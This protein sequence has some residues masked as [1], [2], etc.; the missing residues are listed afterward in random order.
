MPAAGGSS[1]GGAPTNDR[2]LSLSPAALSSLLSTPDVSAAASPLQRRIRHTRLFP[3]PPP[4]SSSS[5]AQGSATSATSPRI[6]T[7]VEAMTPRTV[8]KPN[9]RQPTTLW[10]PTRLTSSDC[11]LSAAGVQED[12]YTSALSW[13]THQMALALEQ[14]LVLFHPSHPRQSSS[15]VQISQEPAGMNLYEAPQ[16]FHH[17]RRATAVAMSRCSEI[18]CF[19]GL[20]NG[21]VELYEGR[22][23]GRLHCTVAFAMPEPPTDYL[24]GLLGVYDGLGSCSS[25]AAT[26]RAARALS[27][28]GSSV[29]SVSCIGTSDRYPWLGAA[30]TAARGLVALDA[31]RAQP[32]LRFGGEAERG[33]EVPPA[34]SSMQGPGAD[35]SNLYSF[36]TSSTNSAGDG[37]GLS[38]LQ[39]TA[40]Y[41]RQHDR[42]CSV[43]WNSTGS[44][45]ATGS[46]GGVVKV[47]SLS[48]PQRPLHSFL[49]DQEC[50]VKALSFHPERPYELLVGGSAGP[51]GLRTY[52]LSRAAPVLVCRGATAAPVTQALFDPAGSYAVTCAGT[53]IDIATAMGAGAAAAATAAPAASHA[54]PTSPLTTSPLQRASPSGAASRAEASMSSVLDGSPRWRHSSPARSGTGASFGATPPY[55]SCTTR[56][57]TWTPPQWTTMMTTPR[58]CRLS[59][60]AGWVKVLNEASLRSR[61]TVRLPTPSSYGAAPVGAATPICATPCSATPSPAAAVAPRTATATTQRTATTTTRLSPS[62]WSGERAGLA[63]VLRTTLWHVARMAG[64]GRSGCR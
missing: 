30:A 7:S 42:L 39:R 33:A 35:A 19:L 55:R 63:R 21:A 53:P 52:D 47:W 23:D 46:S 51:A 17:P 49:I 57:T 8:L 40:A 14:S 29:S 25:S 16:A 4:M 24:S 54:S 20:S 61:L 60:R 62:W 27:L 48:A 41:L 43:S 28:L 9:L 36:S 6:E 5:A 44:L 3:P 26:S 32:V 1:R 64:R 31:R 58:R 13:G 50:T 12:F 56:G 15:S 59:R 11:V 18:S 10:Q 22:G 38:R 37:G 2:L 34:G 45:V